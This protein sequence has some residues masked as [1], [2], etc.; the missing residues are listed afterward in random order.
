MFISY[1]YVLG[2]HS[3]LYI[4]PAYVTTTHFGLFFLFHKLSPSI[5]S[6]VDMELEIA[7]QSRARH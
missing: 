3:G 1:I 2:Y 7:C 6:L 4:L 5:E